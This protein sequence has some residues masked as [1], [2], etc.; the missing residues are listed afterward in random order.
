V[1]NSLRIMGSAHEDKLHEVR[2]LHVDRGAGQH[3]HR[4]AEREVGGGGRTLRRVWPALW[5]LWWTL[6]RLAEA[7]AESPDL[8]T[9]SCGAHRETAAVT[10]AAAQRFTAVR[11]NSA[12]QRLQT[13]CTILQTAPAPLDLHDALNAVESSLVCVLTLAEPGTTKRFF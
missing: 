8:F 1:W 12:W 4:M 3:A 6:L 7:K 11:I 9:D 13:Q 2:R 5:R 10:L